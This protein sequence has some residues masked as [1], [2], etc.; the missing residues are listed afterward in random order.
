MPAANVFYEEL[1]VAFGGGAIV[2]ISNSSIMPTARMAYG[3]LQ[4]GDNDGAE[5]VLVLLREEIR[6][7]ERAGI[8]DSIMLRGAAMLAAMEGNRDMMLNHLNAAID[9]GL[10]DR[11][12]L[13]E[14]ALTAYQDDKEFQAIVSRLEGILAAER[15][16]TIELVCSNNP[17]PE[18][19][20][21]LPGTCPAPAMGR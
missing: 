11:F 6:S 5:E 9:A 16:K 7:R 19:W 13:R 18:V 17:A 2:D 1:M 12:I 15:R 10:R 8:R 14:P 4:A 21:P 3:L 20:Q